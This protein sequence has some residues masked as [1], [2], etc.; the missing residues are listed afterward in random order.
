MSRVSLIDKPR[1][2]RR[3]RPLTLMPPI[4]EEDDDGRAPSALPQFPP[5]RLLDIDVCGGCEVDEESPS[6]SWDPAVAA[7]HDAAP[8]GEPPAK[9]QRT[10]PAR[11]AAQTVADVVSDEE[12]KMRRLVGEQP[13]RREGEQP[14]AEATGPRGKKRRAPMGAAPVAASAV[15]PSAA[16]NAASREAPPKPWACSWDGCVKSFSKQCGLTSHMCT[17]TGA[18]PFACCWD[19]CVER[20]SVQ[21]NLTRHMSTQHSEE[22][23]ARREEKARLRARLWALL[24]RILAAPSVGLLAL[25][26][27]LEGEDALP[28]GH[29]FN[30]YYV[31]ML[32]RARGRSAPDDATGGAEASASSDGVDALEAA[33]EDDEADDAAPQ[34]VDA[35]SEDDEAVEMEEVE[36]GVT[37][38]GDFWL[39]HQLR[40]KDTL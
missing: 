36:L 28:C 25:L 29:G 21:C 1:T 17:H 13:G 19:G 8:A 38:S 22:G 7:V 23:V 9:R 3:S 33:S 12:G 37:T 14:I 10:L 34:L 16:P 18:Q 27:C 5:L 30:G 20:F 35:A 2:K 39:L 6:G 31:R 4:P 24:E 40:G 26:Q 11:F 32:Q 15:A